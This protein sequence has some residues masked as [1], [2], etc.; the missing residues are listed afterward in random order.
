MGLALLKFIGFVAF[1][2]FSIQTQISQHSDLSGE[3]GQL[4]IK[5]DDLFSISYPEMKLLISTVEG[6]H[7][8]ETFGELT[9]ETRDLSFCILKQASPVHKNCVSDFPRGGVRWQISSMMW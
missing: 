2:A 1:I 8:R 4:A 9:M 6:S 3:S 5:I 7:R